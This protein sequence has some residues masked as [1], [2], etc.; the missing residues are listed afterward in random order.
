M[1]AIKKLQKSFGRLEVLKGISLDFSQPGI[2]A[3]L[4]PNGSGKT[5]LIKTILGMAIPSAG[6]IE[7]QGENIKGR[8]AYRDQIDYLPQIA[9]FPDNLSVQEL[10]KMVQGLRAGKPD[11]ERL[12]QLFGLEPFL[13]KRLGTLSGGTRQKVNIVQALMYDSPILILDEP[14]TG[15]DPVALLHLKALLEEERKRGKLI[16]VT[17]H[18][19]SFVEEMA[20][21]VVFL[22]E[23]HVHFRGSLKSLKE[24][25]AAAS[26]EKAIANILQQKELA[27]R[28][29]GNSEKAAK[30]VFG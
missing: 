12:I 29:N 2:T 21:E 6:S 7:F 25:Y 3:I 9:R 5:T 1:I 30:L 14:T 27:F 10:F 13:K 28:S 20:D 18:I 15:L 17:T 26:L 19:M 4:G 8:W 11:A 16:L 23:G 24:K 22:L